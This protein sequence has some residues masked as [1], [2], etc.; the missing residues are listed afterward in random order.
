MSGIDIYQ[1]QVFAKLAYLPPRD[2]ILMI[3]AEHPKHTSGPRYYY[4][5]D[6]SIALINFNI[7]DEPETAAILYVYD[8]PLFHII[9][10]DHNKRLPR[11]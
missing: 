3:A 7:A 11:N 5:D 4:T 1:D 2:L 6:V 10:S 8:F 9:H